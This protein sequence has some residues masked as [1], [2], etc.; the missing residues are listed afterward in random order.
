MEW[1]DNAV[2]WWGSHWRSIVYSF[3]AGVIMA[4]LIF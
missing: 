4:M 3:F 2:E 1:L